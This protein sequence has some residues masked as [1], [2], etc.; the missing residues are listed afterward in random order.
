[1][2][3]QNTSTNDVQ[4]SSSYHVNI[5]LLRPRGIST[6]RLKL[7][8]KCKSSWADQQTS[9]GAAVLNL[10]S[11]AICLVVHEQSL[12]FIGPHYKP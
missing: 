10:W 2:S 3:N 1:M 11:T 7:Q 8:Q 4:N 12:T 9:Y 5:N 6:I